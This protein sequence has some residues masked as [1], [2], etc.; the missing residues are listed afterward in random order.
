M[1]R[2]ESLKKMA[3]QLFIFLAVSMSSVAARAGEGDAVTPASGAAESP[4]GGNA[5][6]PAESRPD[7]PAPT[8]LARMLTELQQMRETVQ[9]Q[10]EKIA[11]QAQELESERA[12][13]LDELDR[14]A[15]LEAELHAPSKEA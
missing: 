7:V 13:V 10:S 9:G 6:A 3:V 12:A 1:F 8:P 11:K 4:P 15:R 5:S 2:R 14:I